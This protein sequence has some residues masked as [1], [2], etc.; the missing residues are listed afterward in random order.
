MKATQIFESLCKTTSDINEHLSTLKKYAEQ[1]ETVTEL[2]V[3]YAVSTW[4]F[5]EAKPKKLRCYDLDSNSYMPSDAIIR[6][7]CLEYNIDYDFIAGDSLVLDIDNTDMLFIDTLHTYNQL[8]LELNKHSK[9]VN[10]WIILHDTVSFGTH[11]EGI[12][13]HASELIK[14]KIPNKT[15]LINAVK[16]FV[17]KNPEWVV[18]EVFYNN[19][20]LT[21][22]EKI[23]K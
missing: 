13:P 5:I 9:N 21:V 12:Y 20:G 18:K 1:C 6:E 11:D 3:R 7:S 23:T 15:G 4:S 2:G 19:N 22:L 10:K 17:D 16:E 14:S 8:I